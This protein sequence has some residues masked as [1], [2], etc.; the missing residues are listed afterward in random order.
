MKDASSSGDSKANKEKTEYEQMGMKDEPIDDFVETAP[1]KK[2]QILG[3]QDEPVDD[4]ISVKTEENQQQDQQLEGVVERSY[5]TYSAMSGSKFMS[6]LGAPG[7]D[8]SVGVPTSWVLE[9]IKNIE[10][11]NSQ[12]NTKAWPVL[13]FE[14]DN[15][16][17]TCRAI[18][19]SENNT[20]RYEGFWVNPETID[21]ER[22]LDVLVKEMLN[23]GEHTRVEYVNV[24]T[25]P[26]DGLI[27]SALA[28]AG[29]S[30]K[31]YIKDRS[32]KGMGKYS[33]AINLPYLGSYQEH[34]NKQLE[35]MGE[36]VY[37]MARKLGAHHGLMA[38]MSTTEMEP[39]E[40]FLIKDIKDLSRQE[41]FRMSRLIL[42]KSRNN[43][44]P[45]SVVGVNQPASFGFAAVGITSGT[46]FGA[47]KGHIVGATVGM[48]DFLG[49][50]GLHEDYVRAR[51]LMQ[52]LM[53]HQELEKVVLKAVPIE[54]AGTVGLAA[55][56][57]F[58]VKACSNDTL[59]M[60][61]DGSEPLPLQDYIILPRLYRAQYTALQSIKGRRVPVPRYYLDIAEL[62]RQMA[63]EMPGFINRKTQ[64]L[65]IHVG[66]VLF[67]VGV[68]L[69]ARAV[70]QARKREA[71][72]RRLR[73]AQLPDDIQEAEGAS[74]VA[75]EE[76]YGN[77]GVFG[78]VSRPM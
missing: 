65:Y 34:R 4:Y 59:M 14:N 18:E 45:G 43:M 70:Q 25:S 1:M 74:V 13:V 71:Q 15:I 76:E 64:D 73:Y 55:E 31:Q 69:L 23:P 21:K 19:D 11:E 51:L 37:I 67:V 26:T 58:A 27:I 50:S 17:C 35:G 38:Y 8:S 24:R 41:M 29:L 42:T 44:Y 6:M 2:H 3:L 30:L 72:R 47:L 48:I 7:S 12:E 33:W 32:G 40:D 57:G 62:T 68:F 53:E 78:D 28:K 20:L 75:V 61:R 9:E 10:R 77:E 39:F 52:A 49:A 63:H 60:V 66:A 36:T 56:L 5:L 22:A 46:V 16:V 54:D